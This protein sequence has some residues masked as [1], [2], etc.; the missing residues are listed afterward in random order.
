MLTWL[1][2][3]IFSQQRRLT[4]FSGLKRFDFGD[5][6]PWQVHRPQPN[7]IL[8]FKSNV[9]LKRL[10]RWYWNNK[11][12]HRFAVNRFSFVT[13]FR[14]HVFNNRLVI[15]RRLHYLLLEKSNGKK[16]HM[17]LIPSSYFQLHWP[18]GDCFQWEF[19]P[20]LIHVRFITWW[21]LG[22]R[23]VIGSPFISST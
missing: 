20:S 5:I 3:M 2:W 8:I 21:L 4:R 15:K 7:G 23:R 11:R 18:V 1:G 13:F 17:V 22:E 16:T 12:F 14:F 6:F 19:N 9:A 10:S